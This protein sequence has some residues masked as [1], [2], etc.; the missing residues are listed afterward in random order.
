M[1]RN[2]IT[3]KSPI[4]SIR[5]TDSSEQAFIRI[6]QTMTDIWNIINNMDSRLKELEQKKN[7]E[8]VKGEDS[9]ITVKTSQGNK[10]LKVEN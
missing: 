10:R 4:R 8:Y 2:L 3:I 6:N 7:M 1:T 9:I 5:P